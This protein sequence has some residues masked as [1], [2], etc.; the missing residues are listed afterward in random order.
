MIAAGRLVNDSF[1][2]SGQ[3]IGGDDLA[4]ARGRRF[5]E[6]LLKRSGSIET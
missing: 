5:I 4:R 2:H 3:V 6:S 1:L